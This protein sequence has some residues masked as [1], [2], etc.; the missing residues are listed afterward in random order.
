VTEELT[1]PEWIALEQIILSG[2]MPDD[3]LQSRM[4]E[5]PEFAAWLK[6]RAQARQ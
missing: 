3:E 4:R 2:Q 5:D 1:P 6:S